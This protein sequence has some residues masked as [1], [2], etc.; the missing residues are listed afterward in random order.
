M[1]TIYVVWNYLSVKFNSISLCFVLFFP[2]NLLASNFFSLLCR[3]DNSF[4][5][6]LCCVIFRKCRKYL[7]F[8]G[9]SSSAA[10]YETGITTKLKMINYGSVL[11]SLGKLKKKPSVFQCNYFSFSY[12]FF[13]GSRNL[14]AIWTSLRSPCSQ[15]EC[16]LNA[17]FVSMEYAILIQLLSSN[18]NVTQENKKNTTKNRNNTLKT[19]LTIN[20]SKVNAVPSHNILIKSG[21]INTFTPRR[22]IHIKMRRF[23]SKQELFI[24]PLTCVYYVYAH[25]STCTH[26][27]KIRPS[28]PG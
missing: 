24:A 13:T 9:N 16:T 2:S 14:A 21:F 10:Y 7:S 12:Y 20:I 4:A 26:R 25:A 27:F 28:W 6:R 1:L 11:H 17:S 22:F 23:I 3:S 15:P 5:C 18:I 8:T 19:E